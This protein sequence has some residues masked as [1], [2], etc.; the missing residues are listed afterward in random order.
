MRMAA[1]AVISSPANGALFETGSAVSFDGSKS[2]GSGAGNSSYA[3]VAWDW[4]FGDGNTGSGK[5]IDHIYDDAGKFTVTLTVTDEADNT[6]FI[7]VTL[8]LSPPAAPQ[9]IT[10]Q[11]AGGAGYNPA[12]G[13]MSLL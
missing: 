9:E 10:N 4:D 5:F 13:G 2:V 6:A 8:Y 3:I 11:P 12:G 1:A 7:S